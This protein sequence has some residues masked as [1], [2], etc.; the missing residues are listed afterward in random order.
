[1]WGA[2]LPNLNNLQ[3]PQFSRKFIINYNL[4][5]VESVSRYLVMLLIGLPD[6]RRTKKTFINDLN[7]LNIINT[8][9]H[10]LNFLVSNCLLTA[11]SSIPRNCSLTSLSGLY[12][13]EK[14]KKTNFC[15]KIGVSK[16]FRSRQQHKILKCSKCGFCFRTLSS[17]D[18]LC[19]L[20]SC[21]I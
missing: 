18:T 3:A 10:I 16:I 8:I 17:N 20:G 5:T 21:H 1:M 15:R 6:D 12:H 4:P 14:P 2:A 7:H 19:A 9:Y 13:F 11:K